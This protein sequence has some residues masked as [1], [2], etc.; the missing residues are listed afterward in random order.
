MDLSRDDGGNFQVHGHGNYTGLGIFSET[1]RRAP[2]EA[3]WGVLGVGLAGG[4]MGE[5]RGRGTREEKKVGVVPGPGSYHTHDK[6]YWAQWG[7]YALLVYRRAR[8]AEG[9]I[10]PPNTAN[11]LVLIGNSIHF[12]SNI[13]FLSS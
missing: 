13:H 8:N 5:G 9:T 3:V 6:N 7:F 4:S 1:S 12:P 2:P 10:S 11:P